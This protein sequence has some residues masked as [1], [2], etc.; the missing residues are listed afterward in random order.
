MRFDGEYLSNQKIQIKLSIDQNEDNVKES[1]KISV[2]E[3]CV[4][5]NQ[6][7][8]FQ[9]RIPRNRCLAPYLDV[10]LFKNEN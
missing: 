10:K 7:L 4:H 5:F 3:G 8:S 2:R 6:M 9:V 1:K